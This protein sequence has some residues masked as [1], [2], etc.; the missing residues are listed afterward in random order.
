[1]ARLSRYVWVVEAIDRELRARDPERCVLGEAII[2]ATCSSTD[3]TVLAVHVPGLASVAVAGSVR[4]RSRA[5]EA[6]GSIAPGDEGA[7]TLRSFECAPR[8]YGS[9]GVGPV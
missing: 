8:G 4:G 7:G 5:D 1:M 9:G 6:R 2:D 3:P